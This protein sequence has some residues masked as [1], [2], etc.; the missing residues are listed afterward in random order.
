MK[1]AGLFGRLVLGSVVLVLASCSREAGN[2]EQGATGATSSSAASVM[3]SLA[4]TYQLG[5]TVTGLASSGRVVLQNNVS[6][7]TISS[8]GA[9]TF[10]EPVAGGGAYSVT[11]LTQP[12]SPSQTCTVV[13][14]WGTATADVTNV[15]VTCATESHRVSGTITGLKGSLV[16]QNNGG[17]TLTVSA[18][19]SFIFPIPVA[20]GAA[21]SVTV[22]SQPANTSQTCVVKN[23][24][25]TI[26]SADASNVAITCT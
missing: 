11:V 1:A 16:L 2:T 3:S 17:D 8:N 13:D 14:G 26:G 10:P 15:K 18:S 12:S 22:L 23:G 9:F 24:S 6:T 25:G 20:S 19:G 4:A 21:Y 5:G 7:A